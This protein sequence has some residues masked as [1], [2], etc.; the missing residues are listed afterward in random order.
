[1]GSPSQISESLLGLLLC[2]NRPVCFENTFCSID[3]YHS[4]CRAET[5]NYLD[6]STQLQFSEHAMHQDCHQTAGQIRQDK[7]DFII[8]RARPWTWLHNKTHFL[9]NLPWWQRAPTSFK[10]QEKE[11]SSDVV[12]K[13]SVLSRCHL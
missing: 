11:M 3:N 1:M 12:S 2:Q 7:A 8:L 6:L 5:L 4:N 9:D 10:G 13:Q